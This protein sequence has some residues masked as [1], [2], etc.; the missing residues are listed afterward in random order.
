MVTTIKN[1]VCGSALAVSISMGPW[2]RG[3]DAIAASLKF[4]PPS[5]AY[6]EKNSS[7]L[8]EVQQN[9][10]SAI[11]SKTPSIGTQERLRENNLPLTEHPNR[12]IKPPFLFK[13]KGASEPTPFINPFQQQDPFQT[14]AFSPRKPDQKQL[15]PSAEDLLRKNKE[16]RPPAIQF[17][18]PHTWWR[19]GD[20][21]VYELGNC[22]GKGIYAVVFE[23]KRRRDEI[24][25]IYRSSDDENYSNPVIGRI[26]RGQGLLNHYGIPQ[27]EIMKFFPFSPTPY[28]VQAQLNADMIVMTSNE[29]WSQNNSLGKQEAILK[30]FTQLSTSN[31][32]W[33][34]GHLGN[35]FLE[36]I[37]GRDKWRGGILDQDGI[38]QLS[39]A[40]PI[41]RSTTNIENLNSNLLIW[42]RFQYENRL[43]QFARFLSLRFNIDLAK[44]YFPDIDGLV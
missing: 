8:L 27:L 41:R 12:A 7:A 33:N 6:T 17:P 24:I 15:S 42:Q 40:C 11:D 20:G 22:V 16:E 10:A 36:K 32:L 3:I 19:P 43:I 30:L 2:F 44:T 38:E 28:L 14:E 39:N 21:N 37:P 26:K 35:I 25:K 29:I 34:D 4:L 18:S 1:I 13:K 23:L 31:L 9:D 5:I